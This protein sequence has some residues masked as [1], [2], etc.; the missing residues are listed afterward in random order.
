MRVQWSARACRLLP[1][2]SG[3]P[4]ERT[5]IGSRKL[6]GRDG[7]TPRP[8]ATMNNAGKVGKAIKEDDRRMLEMLDRI[9]IPLAAGHGDAGEALH[10][11]AAFLQLVIDSAGLGTWDFTPETG[12]LRWS[13]RC[14]A[15]FGLPPDAPVSY[16]VFLAGI[17]PDDRERCDAAV[18]RALASESGGQGFVLEYRTIGLA[19][20]VERWLETR[21]EIFFVDGRARRFIGTVLDVTERKLSE[22]R[23]TEILEQ[24]VAQ[25]TEALA[26]ANER[27]RAEVAE[28][29]AAEHRLSQAQ[30]IEA[31]GQLTGGIAH[32]FNNILTVI[33]GN[34]ELLRERHVAPAGQRMVD[35]ASRAAERGATLTNQLLAFA[36]RQRLAPRPVDI[37]HIVRAMGE[38]LSH[39][40]GE[41]IT[42]EVALEDGLWRAMVDPSQIEHAILNL[43]LNARDAMAAGGTLIIAAANADPAK[44]PLPDDLPEGDHV[45]IAVTDTGIGM[46]EDV[47]VRAC[48]PFFTTKEVGKGTGLGLSQVHGIVNQSGGTMR[49]R[50]HL[51]QGTTV[52]IFLPR[53]LPDSAERRPP[54]A[55]ALRQRGGTVLVVDDDPDLRDLAADW[56][57]GNGYVALQAESGA[58]AL[59]VIDERHDIDL[60][61]IDFAMPEMN[62]VDLARAARE[63]RPELRILFMTDHAD[64]A[65]LRRS[66]GPTGIL[67]KPFRLTGL[68]A[69]VEDALQIEP[70]D[71]R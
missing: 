59:A 58:A 7:P 17:H 3:R 11:G 45:V 2:A 18:K 31:V 67:E 36:R 50:S 27:L 49:I 54:R 33:Q 61:L 41:M 25:R 13:D 47:V 65:A 43:A 19:D 5:P 9:G 57:A 38:L 62:G 71:C 52:E 39:T 70:S 29:L 22:Q 23:L 64:T 56:L 8:G 30:K 12:E 10:H 15:L 21:G 32:D 4:L 14:K 68:T 20:G 42:V 53:A 28:R 69:M 40:I 24:R 44:A 37:G 46:D 60:L 51:G 48:D 55:A 26:E 16:D 66:A 34:L 1:L 6:P 63:L 35:A